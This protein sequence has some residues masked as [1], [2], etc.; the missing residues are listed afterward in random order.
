MADQRPDAGTELTWVMPAAVNGTGSVVIV[1]GGPAGCATALALHALG[2]DDITVVEAG[3]HERERIGESV[4]PDIGPLLARCGVL[5]AFLEQGHEPCAGSCASWGDDALGYNDFIVN[6]HGPGWHLDRLRFERFLIEQVRA[7]GIRVRVETRFREVERC[8]DGRF[9][10]H[11]QGPA[12]TLA[13]L[14]A[15][16]LIDAGGVQALL[17]T[18]LGARKRIDDQLVVASAFLDLGATSGFSRMTLLEAVE[19][20]WWYAARVPGGRLIVAVACEPATLKSLSLNHPA[21]WLRHVRRTRHLAAALPSTGLGMLKLQIG[22]AASSILTPCA[23]PGWLAVGDAASCF[24]PISAQGLHKAFANGLAAAE[25]IASPA[26]ARAKA[27]EGYRR[28]VE[29]QFAEYLRNREY[30][31]GLERRWPSASFWQRRRGR[32]EATLAI[33]AL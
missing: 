3:C 19:Y 23:G 9:V 18:R 30:F 5:P 2:V 14:H 29:Q 11:V 8:P 25:V 22:L 1:G 15:D 10:L 12:H 21:A 20:G 33:P 26:H 31:Y 16:W 13:S 4:P 7:R 24:D 27:I 17:A 28:Q 6:P 32:D